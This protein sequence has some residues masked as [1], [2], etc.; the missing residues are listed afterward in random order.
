VVLGQAL[1][2]EYTAKSAEA[3][4]RSTCK[5]IVNRWISITPPASGRSAG[6]SN[7]EF[8][9]KA[10]LQGKMRIVR[11]L[12]AAFVPVQLVGH[13]TITQFFGHPL[14][15]PVVVPT[16]ERWP[17][18]EG[19]WKGIQGTKKSKRRFSV[20][21]TS[22]QKYYVDAGK[23]DALLAKLLPRVG[24]LASTLN[25]IA[26]LTGARIPGYM[27]GHHAP[28]NAEFT[29][30]QERLHMLYENLVQW[31][32]DVAK[33][34]LGRLFQ[35][36]LELQANALFRRIPHMIEAAARRASMN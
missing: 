2:M 22:R 6:T 14:Q 13:R 26:K 11:D 20:P 31:A 35:E 33:G 15:N 29:L 36:A 10:E 23:Y 1:V 30:T 19:I 9:T 17:D 27:R 24:Y 16:R 18:V 12:R 32:P 3:E 28:Q 4:F 25:D 8:D 21:G 7:A 34:T 5:G